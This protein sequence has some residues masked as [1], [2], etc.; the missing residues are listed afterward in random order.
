VINARHQLLRTRIKVCGVRDWQTAQAAVLAGADAIGLVLADGS[1]RTI[2][3]DAAVGLAAAL[4]PFVH[5]VAVF[6]NQPAS[7]VATWPGACVQI[8]GDEDEDYLDKVSRIG[9]DHEHHVVERRRSQRSAVHF[10]AVG[11]TIIRGF[12]FSREAVRRWNA[13]P[14]V[15]VLLVDGP[16][17][18]TGRA[19]DHSALAAMHDEIDKPLILAGGLTPENVGAA[20][21]ILRPFAVDV[22]SGVESKPGVKDATLIESFCTSV[23]TADARL[24]D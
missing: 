6:R 3:R 18:G 9:I 13:C 11:R 16:A 17:A 7:D 4:P 14:F 5:D 19:F 20:I 24:T 21:E 12:G 22:S 15:H 1:P 23:R 8:H 10:E 2:K